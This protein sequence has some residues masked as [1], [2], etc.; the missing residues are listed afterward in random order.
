MSGAHETHVLEV[1]AKDDPQS[2]FR[3]D[4]PRDRVSMGTNTIHT[5]WEVRLT[6]AVAD[7]SG[8]LVVGS[9]TL[10]S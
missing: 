5:G 4:D 7:H 1:G 10:E 6:P 2:F 8:A 3:H 9:T